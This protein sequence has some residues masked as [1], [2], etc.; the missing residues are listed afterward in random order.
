MSILSNHE[1]TKK[2]FEV[3]FKALMPEN[4]DLSQK[5][6]ITIHRKG[7]KPWPTR[8]TLPFDL[9][10]KASS[11]TFWSFCGDLALKVMDMPAAFLDGV[12]A[13]VKR[14]LFDSRDEDYDLYKNW[15]EEVMKDVVL[16]T[17]REGKVDLPKSQAAAARNLTIKELIFPD[18]HEKDVFS[19]V[20]TELIA[21]RDLLAK[22]KIEYKDA[23]FREEISSSLNDVNEILAHD[24]Q[25]TV[26][27]KRAKMAE[28]YREFIREYTTV[29]DFY[30]RIIDNIVTHV[31]ERL[32][33]EGEYIFWN[34][35]ADFLFRKHYSGGRP[36]EENGLKD[37]RMAA[38]RQIYSSAM[39]YLSKLGQGWAEEKWT[40]FKRR[41]WG[42]DVGL[43]RMDVWNAQVG[44]M[45]GVELCR[46][47]VASGSACGVCEQKQTR[48]PH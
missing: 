5:R 21:Y 11:K 9:A 7:G 29:E 33:V 48:L 1:V 44:R 15:N 10:T 30:N 18:F 31:K 19:F 3:Y 32:N 28:P 47:P 35:K 20:R 37:G 8:S 12:V 26:E 4:M 36:D 17:I 42:N 6:F 16:D 45:L 2:F 23:P 22:W 40:E 38:F 25:Y 41:E 14:A 39:W 46:G 43:G 24:A 34:S 27:Q 13:V